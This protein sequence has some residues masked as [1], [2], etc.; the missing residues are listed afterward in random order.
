MA[1]ALNLLYLR[2]SWEQLSPQSSG[3]LLVSLPCPFPALQSLP[4]YLIL[5]GW[6]CFFNFSTF[7]SK[8][9]SFLTSLSTVL[10]NF[11]LLELSSNDTCVGRFLFPTDSLFLSNVVTLLTSRFLFSHSILTVSEA[12][13][14]GLCCSTS[15]Y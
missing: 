15:L 6:S 2:C 13:F 14:S 5:G 11:Y 4:I 7:C 8:I 9:I 3:L 1:S 12:G 10:F